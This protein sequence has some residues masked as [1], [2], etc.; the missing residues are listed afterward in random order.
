MGQWIDST[1]LVSNIEYA[2]E[3]DVRLVDDSGNLLSCDTAVAN[4]CPE[5][6]LQLQDYNIETRES[7]VFFSSLIGNVTSEQDGNGWYK[8]TGKII[9]SPGNLELA[10]SGRFTGPT[11]QLF[12]V[13]FALT[14]FF[15]GYSNFSPVDLSSSTRCELSN[16]QRSFCGSSWVHPS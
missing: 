7:H 8:L 9:F 1:C 16:R 15:L 12:L 3:A 5:A 10:N 14:C 13:V 11:N 6:T 2:F 4:N